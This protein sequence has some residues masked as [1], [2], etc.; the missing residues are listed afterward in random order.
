MAGGAHEI[1]PLTMKAA[2][3]LVKQRFVTI[4]DDEEVSQSGTGDDVFGVGR[5]DISADEAAQG[6]LQTIDVLGVAW[7]EAGEAIAAG[8]AVG[9]GTDGKAADGGGAGIATRSAAADGDLITV[10]LTPVVGA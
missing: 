8:A 4:S 9:P 6:K 1:L 2:E 5:Y 3:A 10:L 7:V